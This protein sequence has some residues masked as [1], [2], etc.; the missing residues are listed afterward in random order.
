MC[1]P[2]Y[3]FSFYFYYLLTSSIIKGYGNNG[4]PKICSHSSCQNIVPLA[5]LGIKQPK[6]GQKCRMADA[7]S[8]QWKRQAEQAAKEAS[9]PKNN[10]SEAATKRHK[11]HSP[12]D[13]EDTDAS[14]DKGLVSH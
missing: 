9:V 8:K 3:K 2:N 10:S 6:T 1:I 5:K 12:L 13:H 14:D 11:G 7:A 4:Y